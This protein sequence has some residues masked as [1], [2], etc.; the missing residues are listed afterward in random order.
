M[1]NMKIPDDADLQGYENFF[2]TLQLEVSG[3]H[4]QVCASFSFLDAKKT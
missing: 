1:V 2:K 4:S 3:Q